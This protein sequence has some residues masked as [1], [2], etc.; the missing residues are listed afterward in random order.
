MSK[1]H[2]RYVYLPDLISLKYLRSG[3]VFDQ[4]CVKTNFRADLQQPVSSVDSS[5]REDDGVVLDIT[6]RMMSIWQLSSQLF[7]LC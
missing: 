6:L 4:P 1:P 7:Q 2:L 3:R 5:V